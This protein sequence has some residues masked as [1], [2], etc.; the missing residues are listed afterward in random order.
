MSTKFI[1]KMNMTWLDDVHEQ[2]RSFNMRVGVG[3]G[4]MDLCCV[5]GA[6]KGY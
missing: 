5:K 6:K 3:G 4:G 2:H 1:K